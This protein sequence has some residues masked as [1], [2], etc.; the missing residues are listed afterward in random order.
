MQK[1]YGSTKA[2][3]GTLLATSIAATGL[4]HVPMAQQVV[5]PLRR[6]FNDEDARKVN[7]ARERRQRRNQKRLD[8]QARNQSQPPE[9]GDDYERG[10]EAE[11]QV[12][13]GPAA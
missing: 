13:A 5:S 1:F 6:K 10:T 12:A 3:L 4:R 11:D 2:L 7:E 8:V 9:G